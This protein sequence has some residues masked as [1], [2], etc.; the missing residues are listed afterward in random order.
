MSRQNTE[1]LKNSAWNEAPTLSILAC[2]ASFAARYSTWCRDQDFFRLR[3]HLQALPAHNRGFGFLHHS[4]MIEQ[5]IC[6]MI[7]K[8]VRV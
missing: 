8:G 1:R 3:Q 4:I 7:E 2:P 5:L 6:G